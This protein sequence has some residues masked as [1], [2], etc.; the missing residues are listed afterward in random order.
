MPGRIWTSR[1]VW[2]LLLPGLFG[3]QK[4]PPTQPRPPSAGDTPASL[5]GEHLTSIVSDPHQPEIL[6]AGSS[7][8]YTAGKAGSLF[9][10]TDG[11]ATWD[12]LLQSV[13]VRDIDLQPTDSHTVYL[14]CGINALTVPGILKSVDGGQTWTAI[15]Q[16]MRLSWEEGPVV[17]A[18]DPTQPE[19]LFAG[20]VGP[21]GGTIYKSTN[22]GDQWMRIDPDSGW[23]MRTTLAGDS[24]AV[25]PLEGG[26][27][28]I[29]LDPRDSDILYAGTA[30]LGEV[31][32][33]LD[34]GRI[35]EMTGL[36]G[37][38]GKG[39]ITD[40]AVLP[41][42]AATLLAGTWSDGIFVSHD[43][44]VIW[45]AAN[46]GLPRP[47]HITEIH[48][49]ADGIFLVAAGRVWRSPME[50]Y[51]WTD[52][53]GDT[54]PSSVSTMVILETQQRILAGTDGEGLYEFTY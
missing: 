10:S 19:T 12:T 29:A 32:K 36:S 40:L 25:D 1:L 23:T 22:G 44:G 3:C 39:I 45:A 15:T 38:N 17:L 48:V 49:T 37:S 2:I 9:K 52:L 42:T 54:I 21:F 26:V 14:T 16:G 6:Y 41:D 31:C 5:I 53:T 43:R 50:S 47:V 11:G 28:T 7:S 33:T 27:T 30:D 46:D 8:D 13:T 4:A 24:G 34:G 35:W 51:Q 20:T 18:M